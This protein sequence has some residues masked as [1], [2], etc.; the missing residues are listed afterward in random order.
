MMDNTKKMYIDQMLQRNSMVDTSETYWQLIQSELYGEEVEDFT[1]EQI[2]Q[3][4]VENERKHKRQQDQ[5]YFEKLISSIEIFYDEARDDGSVAEFAVD[6][7]P[8]LISNLDA[9]LKGFAAPILQLKLTSTFLTATEC[10]VLS[11]NP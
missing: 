5:T 11:E 9:I 6:R 3:R 1:R 10:H 2:E 4:R 7:F 8:V